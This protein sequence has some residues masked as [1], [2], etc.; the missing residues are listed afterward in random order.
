MSG[1]D[2]GDRQS[3]ERATGPTI[4]RLRPALTSCA[5]A[6]YPTTARCNATPARRA[7]LSWV[8]EFLEEAPEYGATG[9]FP[10]IALANVL[11]S[12]PRHPR[13]RVREA[14]Y[15]FKPIN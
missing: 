12:R 10:R 2:P 3:D 13:S 5:V 4:G 1:T 11:R 8:A 14:P 6:P 9:A 15:R 7:V